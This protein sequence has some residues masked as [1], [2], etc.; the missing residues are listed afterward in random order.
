MFSCEVKQSYENDVHLYDDIFLLSLSD[1]DIINYDSIGKLLSNKI[2]SNEGRHLMILI[3][4]SIDSVN[5][6]TS[7]DF[8]EILTS[9]N[10]IYSHSNCL[11]LCFKNFDSIYVGGILSSIPEIE[12]NFVNY[13]N[14]QREYEYV[15]PCKPHGIFQLG[16]SILTFSCVEM[17][18]DIYSGTPDQQ[19]WKVYFE[20]IK[21][22]IKRTEIER[23]RM[24]LEMYDKLFMHLKVDEKKEIMKFLSLRILLKFDMIYCSEV[25]TP[26][27]KP[28]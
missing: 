20:T 25:I 2:L 27:P 19:N 13:L 15:T 12:T 18:I 1:S 10:R 23:N 11:E 22:L 8:K 17:G 9:K 14:F 7:I 5:N 16:D 4:D 21:I 28:N 6:S 26:Q 3:Y 24:S